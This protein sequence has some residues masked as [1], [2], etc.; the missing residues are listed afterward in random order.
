MWFFQTVTLSFLKD[1]NDDD[2]DDDDDDDVDSAGEDIAIEEI[3]DTTEL[4]I[5]TSD[6][7][8]PDERRMQQHNE[9]PNYNLTENFSENEQP[10]A[11]NISHNRGFSNINSR[12]VIII[13]SV[14]V[15]NL[16]L[17]KF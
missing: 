11:S 1:K 10:K 13:C 16:W 2:D 17:R 14:F 9:T 4:V 12:S 15:I 3:E 5:S 8:E 7:P 6:T